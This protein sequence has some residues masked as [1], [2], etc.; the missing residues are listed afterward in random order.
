MKG[1][2]SDLHGSGMRA[3]HV[4]VSLPE[5]NR[6]RVGVGKPRQFNR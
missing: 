3:F 1:A 6:V 4:F 5:P 2:G